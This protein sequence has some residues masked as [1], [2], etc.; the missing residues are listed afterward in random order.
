MDMTAMQRRDC[1]MIDPQ[2]DLL[3][4]E[5]IRLHL[6]TI[7]M[8]AV[9]VV[10]GMAVLLILG[11]SLRRIAQSTERIPQTT[12]HIAQMTAQVLRELRQ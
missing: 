1:K 6:F 11:L 12:E 2:L 3:L 7:G 8:I 9:A 10:V 5:I 4:R